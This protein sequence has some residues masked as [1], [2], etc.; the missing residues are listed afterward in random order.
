LRGLFELAVSAFDVGR[1][2]RPEVGNDNG[3]ATEAFKSEGMPLTSNRSR[4][5]LGFVNL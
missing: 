5:A 3:E 4:A 2:F 1:T